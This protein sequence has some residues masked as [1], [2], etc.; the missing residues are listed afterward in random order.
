MATSSIKEHL[1]EAAALVASL[2]D[3]CRSF[4]VIYNDGRQ[5]GLHTGGSLEDMTY[6]ATCLQ[7]NIFNQ[8]GGNTRVKQSDTVPAAACASETPT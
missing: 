2:A 3:Q 1:L 6:L 4:V 5:V 7:S 8:L